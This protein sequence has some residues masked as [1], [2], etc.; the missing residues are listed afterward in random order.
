MTD[1]EKA[2]GA[3]ALLLSLREAFTG[4]EWV[5]PQRFW[6]ARVWFGERDY[7]LIKVVSGEM[8]GKVLAAL[9]KADALREELFANKDLAQASERVARLLA[10]Q[11][12]AWELIED[13]FTGCV[14][15][16]HLPEWEEVS[17]QHIC[18]A[19][20]A[21]SPPAE[22]LLVLK[23]LPVVLVARVLIGIVVQAGN[24]LTKSSKG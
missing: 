21:T 13:I 8:V 15:E 3:K 4:V 18:M 11:E 14:C 23:S 5:E 24:L 19:D 1:D 22:R 7:A 6:G 20:M 12:V 2:K 16:L 9:A 17:G 10:G